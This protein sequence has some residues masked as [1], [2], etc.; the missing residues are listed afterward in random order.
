[1]VDPDSSPLFRRAETF[2]DSRHRIF[3][4]VA[5]SRMSVSNAVSLEIG[6]RIVRNWGGGVHRYCSASAHLSICDSTP[7]D[8]PAFDYKGEEPTFVTPA[9]GVIEQGSS[10]RRTGLTGT[11]A[12]PRDT[13]YS[14]AIG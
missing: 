10:L 2:S 1:M 4:S 3:S 13:R 6:P 7:S 9:D 12:K 5:K 8:G 11:Q 14:S